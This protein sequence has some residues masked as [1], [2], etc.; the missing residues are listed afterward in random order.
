MWNWGPGT[1]HRLRIDHLPAKPIRPA[2]RS[3]RMMQV[4]QSTH[5][6]L[7]LEGIEVVTTVRPAS[8]DFRSGQLVLQL[9][10]EADVVEVLAGDTKAPWQVVDTDG[11]R[12]GRGRGAGGGPRASG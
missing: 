1:K 10:G 2:A 3:G 12:S 9:Q 6:R 8:V 7:S 11:G 5:Y 4:S